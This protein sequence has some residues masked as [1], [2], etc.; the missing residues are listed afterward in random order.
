MQKYTQQEIENLI[1]LY[2]STDKLV[3]KENTQR[4]LSNST[5]KIVDI[6]EGSGVGV[7]TLYQYNKDYV[8]NY[9][10]FSTALKLANFLKIDIT[11]FIK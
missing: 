8:T 6:A 10:N 3:I 9:P 7:Q 1:T 4:I 5:L 2:N 11:D